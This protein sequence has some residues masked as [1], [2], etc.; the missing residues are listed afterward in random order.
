MSTI[1]AIELTPIIK[2]S[3]KLLAIGPGGFRK[4]HDS[5]AVE[6]VSRGNRHVQ[7][8]IGEKTVMDAYGYMEGPCQWH[9]IRPP[10]T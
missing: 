1:K 2:N 10:G 6:K 7:V 5:I 8:E 9:Q 4:V 3:L